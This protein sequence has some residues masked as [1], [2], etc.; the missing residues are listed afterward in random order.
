MPAKKKKSEALNKQSLLLNKMT[1]STISDFVRDGQGDL[2][3]RLQ[4]R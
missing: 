1:G 3:S 4:H 2:N